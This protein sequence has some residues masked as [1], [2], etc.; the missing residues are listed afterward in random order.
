LECRLRPPFIVGVAVDAAKHGGQ[1]VVFEQAWPVVT[2]EDWC[3][4]EE[5][6]LTPVESLG[7]SG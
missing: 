5:P 4:C 6:A 1:N 7:K 2:N 3:G